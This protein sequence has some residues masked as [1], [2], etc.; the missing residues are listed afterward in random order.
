ML[1]EAFK[2]EERYGRP[3]QNLKVRFEKDEGTGGL[4]HF[5][6]S[7]DDYSQGQ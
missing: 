3:L 2:E 4:N 1:S 6:E 5:S 7:T